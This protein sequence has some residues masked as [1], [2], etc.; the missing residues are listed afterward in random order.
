MTK[1]AGRPGKVSFTYVLDADGPDLEDFSL[2]AGSALIKGR[3]ELN[4]QNGLDAASF[5]QFRLSPGDN[6]KIDAKRDGNVVKL[7]VRGAVADLRPF[8]KDLQLSLIHI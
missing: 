3:I 4:K 6:L 2:E 8:I 7:V 1:P 5:S